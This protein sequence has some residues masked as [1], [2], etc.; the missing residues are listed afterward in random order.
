MGVDREKLK[1]GGL[2]GWKLLY[3]NNIYFRIVLHSK[4]NK[5]YKKMCKNVFNVIIII[6]IR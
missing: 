4:R 2:C 5:G 3:N 1:E 6:V